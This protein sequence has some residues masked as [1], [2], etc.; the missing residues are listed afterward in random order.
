MTT[1]AANTADP[2]LTVSDIRAAYGKKEVLRGVTF[3]LF[4]GEIVALF[5]GNGSGKST[6]LRVIYGL[7]RPTSG[8]VRFRGRPI[9]GLLPHEIRRLDIGYLLQGG[10]IFPGLT[11]AENLALCHTNGPAAPAAPAGLTFPRLADLW[12]RRAGLLSG[13][14]RQILAIEMAVRRRPVLLLLDEPSAGLSPTLVHSIL[15]RVAR[16]AAQEGCAVLLVEQNVEEAQR[17]C[18]RALFLAE[19]RVQTLSTSSTRG[20]P[21]LQRSTS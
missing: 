5:G 13:G 17:I 16:F 8:E 3:A 20:T 18:H 2:L 21:E 11:V 12:H 1:L 6:T 4:P 19:G 15:Q 9:F 10:R 7:L 14:E